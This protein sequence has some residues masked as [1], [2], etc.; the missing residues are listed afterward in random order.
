[1]ARRSYSKKKAS[2]PRRKAAPA[3][4]KTA[5]RP[6]SRSGGIHTIRIVMEQPA[7]NSLAEVPQ[8][9]L[10]KSTKGKFA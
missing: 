4:R 7:P 3:R 10:S 9:S 5:R 1:M 8:A 2:S 6:S